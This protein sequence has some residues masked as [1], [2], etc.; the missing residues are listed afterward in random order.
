MQKQS[1]EL[2]NSYLNDGFV[3]CI[4]TK[5]KNDDYQLVKIGKMQFKRQDTEKQV[6]RRLLRRYNTYYPEY[7]VK[8][9]TR[10]GNCHLTEKAI[11][12]DLKTQSLHYNREI[13]IYDEELINKAFKKAC[14]KYPCIKTL[15]Y[16]SNINVLNNTNK[17]MK[18]LINK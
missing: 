9:F 15:I 2:V 10:T 6:Y 13:Y 5:I 4:L 16:N 18:I 12:K 3:Y 14:D 7:I 1:E 11:F 17:L 8:H